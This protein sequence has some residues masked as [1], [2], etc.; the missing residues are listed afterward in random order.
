MG[1]LKIRF[2]HQNPKPSQGN[3]L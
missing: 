1:K 3:S 2:N